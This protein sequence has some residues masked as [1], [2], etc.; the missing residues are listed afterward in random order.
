M[1]CTGAILLYKIPRVVIGEN[2]NWMGGEELLKSQ[3]VEVIVIN[4]VACKGLMKKFIVENPEVCFRTLYYV[5]DGRRSICRNG[6]RISVRSSREVCLHLPG[7]M[8]TSMCP[9]ATIIHD[10]TMPL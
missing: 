9:G 1:M 6:T 2:E 8:H 4:D 5:C 10:R 3:G 7:K